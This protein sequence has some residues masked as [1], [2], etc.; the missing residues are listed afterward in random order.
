MLYA[1]AGQPGVSL[2]HSAGQNCGQITFGI[3]AVGPALA[4]NHEA[5]KF[6]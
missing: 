2:K 1:W 5:I 3:P 4:G 6:M